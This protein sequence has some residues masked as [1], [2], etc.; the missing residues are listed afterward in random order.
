MGWGLSVQ[1]LPPICQGGELLFYPKEVGVCGKV[2]ARMRKTKDK[3]RTAE[4]AAECDPSSPQTRAEGGSFSASGAL[5]S[6]RRRLGECLVRPGAQGSWESLRALPG[7]RSGADPQLLK[8]RGRGQSTGTEP[9]RF[10]QAPY[11]HPSYRPGQ[12]AG[13]GE[14]I[15]KRR[16]EDFCMGIGGGWR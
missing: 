8:G 14:G 15:N 3:D 4:R 7:V 12:E 9:L 5:F 6:R 13:R 16:S 1:I 11:L 10:R 2:W